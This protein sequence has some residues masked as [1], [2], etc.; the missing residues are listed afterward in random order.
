MKGRPPL[1][2]INDHAEVG[3]DV[4]ERTIALHGIVDA[5]LGVPFH[6]RSSLGV[7]DA[8]TLGDGL[9]VVVGTA[10]GFPAVDEALQ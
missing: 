3:I 8:Q 7:I 9:F 5:F 1:E 4:F 10:A 6:Q 2:R